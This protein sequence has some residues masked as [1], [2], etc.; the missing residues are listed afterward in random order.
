[1]YTC[2]WSVKFINLVRLCPLPPLPSA[3]SPT[4]EKYIKS[5]DFKISKP[6][7]YYSALSH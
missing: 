7:A 4:P 2:T 6:V 5:S 3:L 1:M